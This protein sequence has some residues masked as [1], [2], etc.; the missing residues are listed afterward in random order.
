[1]LRFVSGQSLIDSHITEDIS[2]LQF[3]HQRDTITNIQL[4]NYFV[5]VCDQTCKRLAIFELR[6]INVIKQIMIFKQLDESQSTIQ[7]LIKWIKF[8]I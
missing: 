4:L 7:L 5:L 1:M 3:F 6:P 2:Y 8:G